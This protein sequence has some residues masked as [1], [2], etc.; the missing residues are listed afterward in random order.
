[1]NE[2]KI[3]LRSE[4]SENEH[5][6]PLNPKN[7]EELINDGFV[8]FV[9]KSQN[10]IYKEHEYARHGAVITEKKWHDPIF[11]DFLIIGLKEIEGYDYLDGHK[12]SFFSHSFQKQSGSGD[13]LTKF[14]K[15]KSVIYDFEYFLD[16]KKRKR[17][18]S[19]GFYAGI[20]GG[21]LGIYQLYMKMIYNKNITH[22][23]SWENEEMMFQ[24]IKID[25]LKELSK[26]K[27]IRIGLIGANGNCGTG[28]KYT[29]NKYKLQYTTITKEDIENKTY[30]LTSFDILYNSIKLT[31][32]YNTIWFD[33]K[34]IFH[35]NILIVDISCDTKKENNPIAICK[36]NTTWR[37]PVYN[38]NNYVDIISI[39]NLPSLLPRDSSD[40]F[41][42]KY[43]ELLLDFQYDRYDYWSQCLGCY[44]EIDL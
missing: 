34:T 25:E 37:E 22:L 14:K 15:S 26:R 11:K 20:V 44:S 7:I 28:V 10:R 24:Q 31:D 27:K 36:S 2:K 16:K 32:T 38:Y 6:A 5:R 39:D 18:L 30:D 43:C 19:F 35:D 8:V 1:M 9:E 3:F 4:I 17:F 23:T 40:H 12:H 33:S 41:S 13:I 42:N 29:L 21:F